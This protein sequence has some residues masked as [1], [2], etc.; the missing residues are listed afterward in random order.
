MESDSKFYFRS[1]STFIS[2][3]FQS[4]IK[5]IVLKHQ[6]N[7]LGWWCGLI[8]NQWEKYL[9]AYKLAGIIELGWHCVSWR[10]L[11]NK[12]AMSFC[13]NHFR[14]LI[15]SKSKI[16]LY[17]CCEKTAYFAKLEALTDNVEANM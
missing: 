7:R 8:V 3:L 10:K 11:E 5:N 4:P 12:R 9:L 1:N 14:R 13:K 17:Y 16:Q 15:Y 6:R 2:K